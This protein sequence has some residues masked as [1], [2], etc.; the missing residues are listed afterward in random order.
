MIGNIWSHGVL[1]SRLEFTLTAL[2]TAPGF[3]LL[4]H[5]FCE[6]NTV[7]KFVDQMFLIFL[8]CT[9]RTLLKCFVKE[10][11]EYSVNDG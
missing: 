8:K 4:W 11:Q 3:H 2:L 1:I 10:C 5:A 6:D 7:T 9:S